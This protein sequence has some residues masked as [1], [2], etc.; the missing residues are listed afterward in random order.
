MSALP[1]VRHLLTATSGFAR[2]RLVRS[3]ASQAAC[4]ANVTLV[5][6]TAPA[7]APNIGRKRT[8]C[9]VGIDAFASPIA[10]HAIIPPL[11]TSAGLT[12]KNAGRQRTRSAIFP[13]SIEPT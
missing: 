1:I 2:P 12:P 6:D 13:G 8:G 3:P 4:D 5:A 10:A 7:N 9:G 11:T